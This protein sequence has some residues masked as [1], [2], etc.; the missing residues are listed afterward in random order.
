MISIKSVSVFYGPE[1]DLSWWMFYVSSKKMCSLV[2]L[3]QSVDV[4]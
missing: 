3:K 4:N 2:L 1:Y